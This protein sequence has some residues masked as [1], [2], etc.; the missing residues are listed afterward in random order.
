MSRC[1]PLKSD[2]DR[3]AAT[4]P[5][6][7]RATTRTTASGSRQA[8]ASGGHSQSDGR[9]PKQQEAY[10]AAYLS[11]YKSELKRLDREAAER[12]AT[13]EVALLEPLVPSLSSG[14]FSEQEMLAL[15]FATQQLPLLRPRLVLAGVWKTINNAARSLFSIELKQ[16]EVYCCGVGSLRMDG[17]EGYD[18]AFALA[19]YQAVDT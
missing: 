4:M 1:L 16:V 6:L 12:R 19:R 10:R 7:G 5:Q 11:W 14:E 17:E 9:T 2:W 8:V 3:L 13:Y 18:F 15:E